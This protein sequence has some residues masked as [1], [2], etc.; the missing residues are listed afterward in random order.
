MVIDLSMPVLLV[1]DQMTMIRIIGNL[2]K[3]L[4][5]V[6]VDDANSGAAALS[7]MRAKRYGF[8]ISDW[9]MDNMSGY[10][11]LKEVRSDPALKQTPF[12]LVTAETKVDNVIA[13][14]KAGVNTYLIK[15]FDAQTLKKKIESVFASSQSK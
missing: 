5:F 13:A 10:D 11:L 14:R 4:G 12:I 6:N 8:V 7:K 9:H 15:P 1:D 2:L 3:Q